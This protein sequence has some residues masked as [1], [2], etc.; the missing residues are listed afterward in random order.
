MCKEIKSV[1]TIKRRKGRRKGRGVQVHWR[2]I[3]K[4][5]YQSLKVTSNGTSIFVGKKKSKNRMVQ[6]YQYLKWI[7]N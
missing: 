4:R 1:S 3:E 2:T 7:D 6:D 5:V